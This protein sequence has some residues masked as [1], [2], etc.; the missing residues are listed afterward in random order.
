MITVPL[1]LV[2]QR[3]QEQVGAL[4]LIE[5]QLAVAIGG[6]TNRQGRR[7]LFDVGDAC[8]RWCAAFIIRRWWLVGYQSQECITQRAAH[9]LEDGSVQQKRPDMRRLAG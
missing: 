8:S 2:V 6:R 5:G 4:Q 3:D 1:P 9:A 7:L